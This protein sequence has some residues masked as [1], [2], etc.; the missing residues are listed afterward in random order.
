M[1]KCRLIAAVRIEGG[2]MVQLLKRMRYIALA[3]TALSCAVACSTTPR[4][5]S[6]QQLTDKETEARVQSAL[7]AD[8]HIYAQHITVGA[9]NGVVHLGGYVWNDYDLEEAQRVA[10]AVPGVTRVVD[11]MELER[12]GTDNSAVSR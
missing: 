3:V 10:E 12:G 7:T 2:D 5:T 6:E 9:D 1:H 11:E 4:K 8:T